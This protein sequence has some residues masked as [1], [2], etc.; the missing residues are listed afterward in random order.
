MDWSPFADLDR[1]APG[2]VAGIASGGSLEEWASFG[3]TAPLGLALTSDSTFYVA[4]IAKQFTAAALAT[5]VLDGRVHLDDSVRRWLPELSSAWQPVQLHH[6]LSHTGG[7]RDSKVVD[8]EG[9]WGVDASMTTWDR[10]TMIAAASPES[11]PGVIHRYSNHG[12]V[13]LAAV[14]ERATGET[15]GE[16]AR[17]VLFAPVGMTQSRFLDAQ[18]PAPVPGWAGG[19]ERV[20]IQ[21]S[22]AGDGGLVT[23][24]EDLAVWD[25]WLPTSPVAALML[26]TR[27][28]MP[29][30]RLAHDAWGISIRSHHGLRIESHGGAIDGY[31]AT[32]V[33]FPS[34]GLSVV[35]L[36]NTDSIADWGERTRQLA[37]SLLADQLDLGRPPWN[38][39]HGEPLGR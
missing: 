3:S 26:T 18:G 14:I 25:G 31:M 39:T 9:G 15:F 21:F 5:L 20:D 37:D 7:L 27:P 29:N 24:L 8:A 32:F 17:R 16:F 22:C 13:L 38:E 30:G 11:E 1:R 23:T 4:S 12:Y 35:V 19:T 34:A 28:Q 10:V 33:R 6:L 2:L 36:A